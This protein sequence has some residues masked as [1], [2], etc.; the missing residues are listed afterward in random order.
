MA[1]LMLYGAGWT[2]RWRLVDGTE[3]MMREEIFRVGR[4]ETTQL[5]VVDP[6]TGDPAM[7]VVAWGQVASA[8]ILDS[9]TGPPHD[10]QSGQYA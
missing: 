7:L 2:Q 5:T 4:D 9:G 6:G 8:V 1:Y 10:E 3:Q